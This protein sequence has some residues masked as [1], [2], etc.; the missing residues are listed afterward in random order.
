MGALAAGLREGSHSLGIMI[1]I[2][3]A[4]VLVFNTHWENNP[5]KKGS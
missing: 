2:A 5:N 4:D 1:A 3:P